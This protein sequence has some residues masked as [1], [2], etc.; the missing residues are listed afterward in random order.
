LAFVVVAISILIKELMAQYA[1]YLGRKTDNQVIMADGWHHRSDSL[2]SVVVL[3][4]IAATKFMP[5][6]WWMDSVLGAFCALAIFHAAYEIMKEA[7]TKILGE[8]PKQDFIDK[9]NAE[10]KNIY[11]T[12]LKLHHFHLHNY[13]SHKELTF[14]IMLDKNMTIEKGHDIATVIEN[15]VKEKFNMSATIHIEPLE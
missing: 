15:M 6:L 8:E 14:H 13:V 4:G 11:G 3:V 9:L 5:N 7:V 10:V 2:S 12:N 1:F